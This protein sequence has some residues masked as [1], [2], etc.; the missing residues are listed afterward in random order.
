M[1]IKLSK[2][3]LCFLSTKSANSANS[4]ISS[5]TWDREKKNVGELEVNSIT[6]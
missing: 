2:L 5:R 6:Q 1:F 4:K 3:K